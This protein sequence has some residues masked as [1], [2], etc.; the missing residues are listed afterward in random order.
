MGKGEQS[1]RVAIAMVVLVAVGFGLSA[2]LL[3]GIVLVVAWRSWG[4][5]HVARRWTT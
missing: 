2:G 5:E 1:Y 4:R 3:V